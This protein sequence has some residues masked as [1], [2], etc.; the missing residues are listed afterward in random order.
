MRE[1]VPQAKPKLLVVDD[2]IDML[3]Y[4]ERALRR[5]YQVTRCRNSP[6]ALDILEN[7]DYEVL[8]TDQKMPRMNGLE[9]LE[10]LGSRHPSL[11]R[12]L[13]S[14]FTEVPAIQRAVEM[15]TIH[16]YILKPVDTAKLIAGIERAYDVRDGRST[17]ELPL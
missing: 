10:R 11:V 12:V 14:G 3:D 9:L 5:R 16:N 15:C 13:L 4:I 7:G 17:I 2:E 8:V 6:K 1:L